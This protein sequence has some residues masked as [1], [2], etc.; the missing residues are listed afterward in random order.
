MGY[1]LLKWPSWLDAGL[2]LLCTLFLIATAHA[3]EIENVDYFGDEYQ[4]YMRHTSMFIPFI[5]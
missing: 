2:A 1:L 5:F 3:E 4:E